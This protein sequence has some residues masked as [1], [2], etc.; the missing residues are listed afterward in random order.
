MSNQHENSN[1]HWGYHGDFGKSRLNALN[2]AI[3]CTIE[4]F[5]AV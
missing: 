4:Q 2:T 3:Y 5:F 1:F